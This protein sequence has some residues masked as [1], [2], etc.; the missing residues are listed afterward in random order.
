MNKYCLHGIL[1]SDGIYIA[2]TD[3]PKGMPEAD[4][5]TEPLFH[6]ST[7]N[8]FG[9]IV[10]FEGQGLIHFGIRLVNNLRNI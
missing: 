5:E 6:R 7:Q 1:K 10:I 3:S 8:N 2:H 4:G 9:G